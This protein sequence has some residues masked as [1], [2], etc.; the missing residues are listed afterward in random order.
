MH[1]LDSLASFPI[2]ALCEM[3][4]KVNL[5]CVPCYAGDLV[6]DRH[7]LAKV[8]QGFEDRLQK[9]ENP[10]QDKVPASNPN[11]GKENLW[12][13]ME[14]AY[15]EGRNPGYND[16]NGYANEIRVIRDYICKWARCDM[17]ETEQLYEM[18]SQQADLAAQG[19]D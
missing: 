4:E 17:I 12:Q 14:K 7:Q 3:T 11:P 5:N 19:L 10:A 8:L 18:L 16:R 6:P 13:M 9:L 15:F 1:W 2:L